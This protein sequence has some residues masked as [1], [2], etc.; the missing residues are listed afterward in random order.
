MAAGVGMTVV[1]GLAVF[2]T[3]ATTGTFMGASAA[4]AASAGAGAAATAAASAILI[5]GPVLVGMGI[6]RAINNHKVGDRIDV[7]ATPL[8]L[9]VAAGSDE[10]LDVFVPLSPSPRHVSIRYSDAQGDHQVEID[11]RQALAGL[12]LPAAKP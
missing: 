11:T 4:S 12:H 6:V 8:P 2:A 10:A 3:S 9:L 7:R 1:G 5:G